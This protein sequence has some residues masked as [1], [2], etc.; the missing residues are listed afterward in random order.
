MK[1]NNS[2]KALFIIFTIAIF[3]VSIV[4][5]AIHLYQDI[6]ER[7]KELVIDKA[8]VNAEKRGYHVQYVEEKK[9]CVEENNVKYY[10][11]ADSKKAILYYCEY[12]VEEEGV[13]VKE[14]EVMISILYEDEDTVSVG[15]DDMR[16]IIQEDGT[17]EMMYCG[18]YFICNKD[19]E[20]LSIKGPSIVD[21][22]QK[23]LDAYTWVKKFTTLED[24][25]DHYNKALAICE[26]LN[27]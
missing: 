24:L 6:I 8:F 7:Q 25:K 5:V 15:Y 17:E 22:Y 14:G 16:V 1:K 27:S 3:L 19:F 13:E 21:G 4:L 9:L 12:P 20:E 23:A 2:K 26:Q 11:I 10:F 18:G